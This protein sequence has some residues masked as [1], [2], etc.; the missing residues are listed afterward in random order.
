MGNA[1]VSSSWLFAV[2]STAGMRRERLLV[3]ETAPRSE[4]ASARKARFGDCDERTT[5]RPLRAGRPL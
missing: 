1:G 3:D 5:E 2:D 4:A